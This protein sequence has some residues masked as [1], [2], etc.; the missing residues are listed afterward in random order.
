MLVD[1][2]RDLFYSFDTEELLFF[3]LIS[4]AVRIFIHLQLIR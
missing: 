2:L 1:P 3:T 4:E